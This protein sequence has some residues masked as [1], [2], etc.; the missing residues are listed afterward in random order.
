MKLVDIK[1]PCPACK[2][3]SA[4]TV[5]KPTLL[6]PTAGWLKCPECLCQIQVQIMFSKVKQANGQPK[7]DV[8]TL[9]IKTSERHAERIRYQRERDA[10][11]AK[12]TKE[13]IDDMGFAIVPG[14]SVAASNAVDAMAMLERTRRDAGALIISAAPAKFMDQT[15]RER[16]MA[17][18]ET[19]IPK[20]EDAIIRMKGLDPKVT[21]ALTSK[22]SLNAAVERQSVWFSHLGC[23]PG[24]DLRTLVA[25]IEVI[26]D[27][28]FETDHAFFFGSRE[29]LDT[30]VVDIR[31]LMDL[32][33]SWTEVIE[34]V[35]TTFVGS[36]PVYGEAFG[37]KGLEA[38][39][40]LNARDKAN[41]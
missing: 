20:L 37:S 27:P 33:V 2:H 13:E 39:K 4:Q 30:F 15:E 18:G 17:E 24:D 29:D 21:H 23:G 7:L 41:T 19:A 5:H 22:Q 26:T 8:A 3:V 40:E 6:T 35:K 31:K 10:K 25:G 11:R 32:G 16:A 14:S 1:F 12:E 28:M 38:L 36:V 34:A 9:Q